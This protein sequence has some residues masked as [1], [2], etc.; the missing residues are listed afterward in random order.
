MHAILVHVQESERAEIATAAK[1]LGISRKAFMRRAAV[2][3]A[4]SL[5]GTDKDFAGMIRDIHRAVCGSGASIHMT[6]EAQDAA[7]ALVNLGHSKAVAEKRAAAI[8][9]ADPG[10][11]A[12]GI[13]GR[14]CQ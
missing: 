6:P 11:D 10:L 8:S 5:S 14:A 13:I 4:Q 12:A 2:Q 3:L 9:I 7:A 1:A